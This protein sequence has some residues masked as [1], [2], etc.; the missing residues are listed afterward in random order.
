MVDDQITL[1]ERVDLFR[2]AA[3]GN[4]RV[5]HGGKIDDGGNAGKVLH[6]DTGRSIRNFTIRLAIFQP[7][8]KGRHVF[9]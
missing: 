1:G 3:E 8:A 9:R 7:A 2:V 4:H 6:Q 5:A